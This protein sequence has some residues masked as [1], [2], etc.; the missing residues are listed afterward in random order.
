MSDSP[1]PMYSQEISPSSTPTLLTPSMVSFAPSHQQ[2]TSRAPPFTPTSAPP[3]STT[4]PSGGFTTILTSGTTKNQTSIAS[5]SSSSHNSISVVQSSSPNVSVVS[6]SVVLPQTILQANN[7]AVLYHT[8]QGLVYATPTNLPEGVV[9]NLGQE[10]GGSQQQFITI[11][12]SLSLT[13]AQQLVQGTQVSSQSSTYTTVSSRK[14][15]NR[16]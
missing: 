4:L 10:Q 15:R 16:K 6:G 13:P 14:E 7:N 3:P 2:R 1:E 11:P 5:D 12:V 8:S 9:L